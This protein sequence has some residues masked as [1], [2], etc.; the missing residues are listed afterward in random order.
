METVILIV[1]LVFVVAVCA[2]LESSAEPHAGNE[3]A[4]EADL[5]ALSP[6]AAINDARDSA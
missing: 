1:L 5:E 4:I 2:H 3:A 6:L